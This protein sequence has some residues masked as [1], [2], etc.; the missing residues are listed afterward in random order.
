M[1]AMTA[2]GVFGADSASAA[3]EKAADLGLSQDMGD[4][5]ARQA[6]EVK[7][8]LQ[9]QATS[10]FRRQHIGFDWRTF[11]DLYVWAIALPLRLPEL[12]HHVVEQSRLLGAVGSALIAVFVLAL[13]YSL[14]GRQRL[15]DRIEARL[16]SFEQRIPHSLYLYI[17]PAVR[18][19][20]VALVP[21]VLLAVYTLIQALIAFEAPWFQLIGRL[22]RLWAIGALVIRFL[23]EL[24]VNGLLRGSAQYGHSLFT[25]ARPVVLYVLTGIALVWAAQAFDLRKEILA[26]FQFAI[27]I[28]II[29]VLFL[30]FLKKKAIL[31]LLPEL[32]YP[33]YRAFRNLTEKFYHVLVFFSLL[34]ALLWS[35]G[36]RNLGSV[37]LSKLWFSYAAY[38][39]VMLVYHLLQRVLDR[40]RAQTD[41][42]DESAGQVY[43]SF[44][45]LIIFGATLA[46]LLVVLNLFGLLGLL[47]QI[48]SFPVLE[49][50]Q[51]PV[52]LWVLIKAAMILVIFLFVSRLVQAYLDYKV[53]P[54]MGIEPGLGYA[55]NTFLNYVLLILGVLVALNV[56]GLDLR[57]LLIFAGAA[58]IGIGLGLQ[59]LVASVISGFTLIFG[60]KL[61]K[62]DWIEVNDTMGMVTDIHLR[63][64]NVRTRDNIEYLIP[65]NQLID[66]VL[67][68]YSLGSPLIRVSVPVG[69]AY[70]ADPHQVE[71]ILLDAAFNE[72]LVSKQKQASVAFAA[73]GDNSINFELLVWI[74][75]R[76][77]AVRMVR[78]KLYF[79]IF[80]ALKA[81]GIE[82]PF[83][84]RDLHIRGVA[85]DAAATLA[86]GTPGA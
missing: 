13:L 9:S 6:G 64:T 53:Y 17:L 61:R 38:I 39:A 76:A 16:A 41:G 27:S 49:L 14:L 32:P 81:A 44:R 85:A 72:P 67:V 11:A 47:R 42:A 69:V 35:V 50:G 36:Y 23:R 43:N 83:P 55:I 20:A 65:N 29:L 15:M 62:G 77:V 82:I 73:Y 2:G 71:Q 25:L 18:V 56:V 31:S 8:Q 54:A 58:G 4:A 24:L 37:V 3:E 46:V 75:V 21:L 28:T 33:S 12:W 5:M 57:F 80:D 30:L 70:D 79:A 10:L 74:D 84:Q 66:G 60:G 68:N 63:A 40:W 1:T 34:V 52:S 78:S 26:L 19:V 86:G 22:L 48:L 51:S 45:R 59:S 7:K